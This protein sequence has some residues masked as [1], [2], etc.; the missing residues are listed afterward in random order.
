LTLLTWWAIAVLSAFV[1]GL[2]LYAYHTWAVRRGFIAWSALP[3]NTDEAG[4]STTVV[5]FPPWRR[6]WPWILLSFV[7][8][9]AGAALGAMG[10]AL[11][12]GVR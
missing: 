2:L 12:A 5:S 3:G 11:A 10:T 9:V 4:D 6:L 7:V 8:L 1:G